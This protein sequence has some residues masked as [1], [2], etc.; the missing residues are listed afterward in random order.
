MDQTPAVSVIMPVANLDDKPRLRA[1]LCSLI[2][3]SCRDFEA[4]LIC[5]QSVRCGLKALPECADRRIRML[6][7]RGHEDAGRRR[8]AGIEHSTGRFIVFL[9]SDDAYYGPQSLQT[10]LSAIERHGV[11]AAGGSCLIRDEQQQRFVYRA[12]LI[13]E[14]FEHLTDFGSFQNE[15]GFYRFIYS[16]D[17]LRSSCRFR[18]LRRFQD[19]VFMVECL[20]QAGRLALIPDIIYVYTKGHRQLAWS[21]DMLLDHLH[22]VEL[23]LKLAQERNYRTLAARMLR[24][25]INTRRLRQVGAEW[26]DVQLR[27]LRHLKGRLAALM[28]TRPGLVLAHPLLTA[29]AHGALVCVR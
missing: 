8:N 19:S 7:D 11:L 1:A 2:S 23:V 22:G 4:L 20:E 13:N 9:D 15:S 14:R 16:G 27:Q 3:Q 17:Y 29:M 10:L 18:P 25:I 12:D 6:D 21:C 28:L 26:P 24:N 5:S